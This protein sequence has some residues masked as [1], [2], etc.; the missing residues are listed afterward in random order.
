MLNGGKLLEEYK[1]LW[2]N[3]YVKYI[4]GMAEEGI[5]FTAISIQNEPIAVQTLNFPV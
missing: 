3:F 1:S 5:N 4:K 2:A